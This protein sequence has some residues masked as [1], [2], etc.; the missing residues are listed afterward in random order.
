MD[1]GLFAI[2]LFPA[3]D[4]PKAGVHNTTCVS[5]TCTCFS[6]CFYHRSRFF[7][8]VHLV[9]IFVKFVQYI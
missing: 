3:P 8:G 2:V 1:V 9:H 4:M 7:G 5:A 6:V